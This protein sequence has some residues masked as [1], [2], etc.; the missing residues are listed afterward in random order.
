[1]GNICVASIRHLIHEG[2]EDNCWPLPPGL[3]RRTYETIDL[4]R[5]EK[6]GCSKFEADGDY[7]SSRLSSFDTN[8]VYPCRI[9]F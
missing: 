2:T 7:L 9:N 4:L 1:M 6:T 8:Q 5:T 3:T